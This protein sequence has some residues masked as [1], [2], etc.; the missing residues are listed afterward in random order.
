M[1]IMILDDNADA[2]TV[3][4]SFLKALGHEVSGYTDGMEALLWLS[5]VRPELIIADLQMPE[6]DGYTFV[7]NVRARSAYASMP[8]ICMTGTDEPDEKIAS[9]GFANV[10]RKPVTLA[11]VMAAIDDVTATLEPS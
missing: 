3:I 1:R 10:L 5:D 7:R 2:L 11:D 8:I 9:G 4:G 6:M